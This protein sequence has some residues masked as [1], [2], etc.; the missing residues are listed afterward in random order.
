MTTAVAAGRPNPLRRAAAAVALAALV[1]A[2]LYL[3]VAALHNWPILLLSRVVLRLD[4]A[5]RATV[6][7]RL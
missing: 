7:D 6:D 3:A 2:L 5:E 1:A 4:V